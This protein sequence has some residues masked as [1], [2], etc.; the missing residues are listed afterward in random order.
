MNEKTEDGLPKVSKETL[1]SLREEFLR[2]FD[3]DRIEKGFIKRLI[4]ENPSIYQALVENEEDVSGGNFNI[5]LYQGAFVAYE[6]L[7]KQVEA[8]NLKKQFER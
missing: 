8:E 3:F 2:D 1:D 5:G 7:R 6:L 4:A